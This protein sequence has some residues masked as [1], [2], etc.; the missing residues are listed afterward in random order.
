MNKIKMYFKNVFLVIVG[1]QI[2]KE[3]IK[4][5]VVTQPLNTSQLKYLESLFKPPVWEEGCSVTALA[6][7]QGQASVVDFIKA[8]S[9]R[10]GKLI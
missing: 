2:T 3:V 4:E 6:Y 10:G 1:K 8:W 9:A 5:Q 7:G